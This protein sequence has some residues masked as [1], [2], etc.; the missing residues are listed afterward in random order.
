MPLLEDFFILVLFHLN[1]SKIFSHVI[2]SIVD[3][4]LTNL[5]ESLAQNFDYRT[6][7]CKQW[8]RYFYIF[9]VWQLTELMTG[10]PGQ[11]FR[12]C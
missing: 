2:L 3:N 7:G 6:S 8:S 9:I 12:C 4:F 5:L 10:L 1:V 11:H